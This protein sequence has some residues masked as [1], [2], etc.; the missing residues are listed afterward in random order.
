MDNIIN[1]NN[2][3]PFRD[4]NI[5]DQDIINNIVHL[6]LQQ[7]NGRKCITIIEGLVEN[8]EFSLK[9][10]SK[11]LRKLLNC[12]ASIIVD[13]KNEDKKIIQLSGDKRDDVKKYLINYKIADSINI[14]IHGY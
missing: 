6:R 12:S 9:T 2:I 8:E 7:R 14:K 1:I 10:L 5:I 11:S 13:T 3:D 4:I